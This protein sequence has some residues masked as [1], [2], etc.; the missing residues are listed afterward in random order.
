MDREEVITKLFALRA[1][2]PKRLL[3]PLGRLRA[4]C[5]NCQT[6]T[7][8][9]LEVETRIW[10]FLETDETRRRAAATRT[11]SEE[12]TGPDFV[13]AQHWN[14]QFCTRTAVLVLLVE[15][16]LDGDLQV[17]EVRQVWPERPPRELPPQAPDQ[18]RSLY[19]EA[20]LAENAAAF[21]G[22]AA[23]Y[24]AAVEELVKDR[25]ASNI[26]GLRE[27]GVDEDIVRDLH[28]ARLTGN[29]SLHAGVEFAPEEVEDV[30]TLI[31]DAI[32]ELYVEPARR[33]EMRKAREA[34]RQPGPSAEPSAEDDS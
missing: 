22:A 15:Y 6:G 33:E 23:L 14:C 26:D 3:R 16:P 4:I 5:P 9:E 27:Q 19:R 28:E 17:T 8:L 32:H 13:L 30:A 2:S 34:R 29:W 18:V 7:A 1:I 25:E 24:R 11:S 20:S 31:G 10:P 21:R 12:T